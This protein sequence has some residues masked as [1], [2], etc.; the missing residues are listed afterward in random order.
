MN[1]LTD[2]DLNYGPAIQSSAQF[3]AQLRQQL[4][5]FRQEAQAAVLATPVTGATPTADVT[6]ALAQQ[7]A[8][9]EAAIA[10][11]QRANVIGID[12]GVGAR[13]QV[14]EQIT[15]TAAQ[16]G[17]PAPDDIQV[18]QAA[19][20]LTE[21][22]A[23][24]QAAAGA[25]QKVAAASQLEAGAS[26]ERTAAQQAA[27]AQ[28]RAAAAASA[29]EKTAEE[30]LA[31]ETL[32][33][34]RA[35]Q[36]SREALA[37]TGV[38]AQ[39]VEQISQT[40]AAGRGFGLTIA[41]R[42]EQLFEEFDLELEG[43]ITGLRAYV[44][45]LRRSR[46]VQERIATESLRL[47]TEGEELGRA[48]AELAVVL[49]RRQIIEA[50]ASLSAQQAAGL[51]TPEGELS[52]QRAVAR[53]SIDVAARQAT[54]PEDVQ[55]LAQGAAAR[56]AQTAAV[57]AATV[58]DE[59]YVQNA[60][61][62][63]IAR[64]Q[65]RAAI[66]QEVSRQRADAGLGGNGSTFQRL[67][68]YIAS[69]SGQAGRDPGEFLGLSQ[70][71][72]SRLITTAG[73]AASGAVLYGA[74]TG[75]RDLV[76]EGTELQKQLALI[77]SQF[78]VLGRTVNGFDS[79]AHFA[80]TRADILELARDTNT[81]ADQVAALE[82][83]LAGAF[84][85]PEGLPDF[86]RATTELRS[87][88]K[89]SDVSGLPEKEITDSLTA[90]ALSFHTTFER[91]ADD[92]LGIEQSFG[93]SSTEIVQFAADLAPV[94]SQLGFTATQ[95]EALGAVA[96]QVSGR[97]GTALAEQF[98]RILPG[99][100]DQGAQILTIFQQNK[101]TAGQVDSLA[102]A[103]ASRNLPKVLAELAEGY[104][105]LGP[106]Q[107]NAVLSLVGERQAGTFAA[108]LE[109]TPELLR[110]LNTD[111]GALAGTLDSRFKQVSETVGFS[112]GQMK[113]AFEQLGVA[114]FQAGV[115]DTLKTFANLGT[116]VAD[117]F[118]IVLDVFTSLNDALGGLPVK[119]VAV[120]LAF[121]ALQ[122]IGGF[123][124]SIIGGLTGAGAGAGLAGLAGVGGVG[125]V[126]SPYT[127]RQPAGGGSIPVPQLRQSVT[128]LGLGGLA[129]SGSAG[130]AIAGIVGTIGPILGALAVQQ[131]ISYVSS[132][133]AATAQAQKDLDARVAA[134]I[135]EGVNPDTIRQQAK[136]T[137]GLGFFGQLSRDLPG[138][139]SSKTISQVT[140]DAI[141]KAQNDLKIQQLQAL[142]GLQ[143]Y[144]A[145]SL[146]PEGGTI[147]IPIQQ[148][149]DNLS[150]NTTSDPLNKIAD[151][152]IAKAQADPVAAAA[153]KRIKDAYDRTNQVLTDG[154]A[155][156]AI[157]D[158]SAE[159]VAEAQAAYE[160][161]TGSLEDYVAAQQRLADIL[162]KLIAAGKVAGQDIS[163]FA[164][165]LNDINKAIHDAVIGDIARVKQLSD[166]V[167]AASGQQTGAT[168]I[169]S[170]KNALSQLSSSGE[171]TPTDL[172][173]A[174]VA[175]IQAEQ[176]TFSDFVNSAKT[177]AERAA[178]ESQ[179]FKIDP[180]ARQTIIQASLAMGQNLSILEQESGVLQEDI[181]KIN[182]AITVGIILY[183][184]TAQQTIAAMLQSQRN[185]VQLELRELEA[186]AGS[187]NAIES[188]Q[189]QL[190]GI[191]SAI[192]N[193]ANIT[194]IDP[195]STGHTVQTISDA[196]AQADQ[197]RQEAEQQAE[198]AL[199]V[200]Q[201]LAH[202][203]PIREAQIAAQIAQVQA[204][205]ASTSTERLQAQAALINAENQLA[206]AEAAAAQAQFALLEQQV[207]HDSVAVAKLKVAAAQAALAASQ[208]QGAAA[209][210]QAQAALLQA[211]DQL[212][213]ATFS[214]MTAQQELLVAIA[215][216]A[217]DTVG[218]A[219]LQL[220]IAQAK[221]QQIIGQGGG[222]GEI[223]AAQAQVVAAQAAL[224]DSQLQQ[225]EQS[226]DFA[227]QL[228]RVSVA[229]AIAQLEALLQIPNLTVQ[230]TDEIL[231]KIKQLKDQLSSDLSFNLPS[232]IDVSG[233]FYESRRL[234]QTPV[235]SSYQDNRSVT[236][237]RQ[238]VFQIIGSDTADAAANA[239]KTIQ[240]ALDAPPRNGAYVGVVD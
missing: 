162:L 225:Q 155:A 115:A 230:E 124:G 171:A 215:T 27:A 96:Q 106:A 8:A 179:G 217:G 186:T 168:D 194:P 85:T 205:F 91:I 101:D 81:V 108:I 59:D 216:A 146:A 88:L 180:E 236:D 51:T 117:V 212:A 188:L 219:Q 114:L 123:G 95:L 87:A 220:Q 121:R 128:A 148:L 25:S 41:A 193:A 78:D 213:D 65:E 92:A 35:R 200:Q 9:A 40:E 141:Q 157:V 238:F 196:A 203:D 176:K 46:E 45:E 136:G 231:L 61:A 57:R 54:S 210:A 22:A 105:K 73:F 137:G 68:A 222:S 195:G 72:T 199:A 75:V 103:I 224:R 24:D 191:D 175:V 107:R 52:V 89:F 120:A 234:S 204:S 111:S 36:T 118:R 28:T 174:A 184:R 183:G 10:R 211:Q 16:L 159:S 173:N 139:P 7:Q 74:V 152:F 82:R 239:V 214:A 147:D 223:A 100:A 21:R 163:Q 23:A 133:N 132:V 90:I 79:S 42:T 56:R 48:T 154:Q 33:A 38:G 153:L 13:Q 126:F 125:G 189:K 160:A 49:R 240:D 18:R 190:A 161:G 84:A 26:R 113:R 20:A 167:A 229:Q 109:R 2:I 172:S 47:S 227:L 58:A 142:S 71:L 55:A 64:Q 76:R 198:A 232:E 97:S 182:A 181:G 202:G 104:N 228:G 237:N 77:N 127:F 29:V 93:V 37:G 50:K 156:A 178:R 17:V 192:A 221:L 30:L 1:F 15:T 69:R 5:Q 164:S 116:D 177:A 226:I 185:L 134:R 130:A 112:F 169:A 67:Q 32:R 62:A 6:A 197:R 129:E 39:R 3:M 165:Q 166:A 122:A 149:I 12:E 99:L 206:D 19:V 138:G 233:L 119:I 140:E 235:G 98:G 80:K 218:A 158:S 207:S 135:Q 94:A 31:E 53:A 143:G 86:D 43:G 145:A 170:A 102:Q 201:A 144:Q 4:A 151:A 83:E 14:R 209:V 150:S 63:S 34:A 110:A 66:L 208:G 60:A 70:F 11:A 44:N 187:I 131:I